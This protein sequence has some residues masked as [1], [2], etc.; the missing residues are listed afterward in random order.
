M[1]LL[2]THPLP[3]CRTLSGRRYVWRLSLTRP[4]PYS[5]PIPLNSCR[6][7]M[8]LAAIAR[9]SSPYNDQ[10]AHVPPGA[11]PGMHAVQYPL[12][13]L[14]KRPTNQQLRERIEVL[15]AIIADKVCD[16]KETK[17]N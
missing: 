4:L 12:P 13:P 8:S 6:K 3:Y 10:D 15:E 5:S 11:A 14:P 9:A 2:L 17:L 7:E 1:L 16:G